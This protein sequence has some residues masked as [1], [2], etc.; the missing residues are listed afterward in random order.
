MEDPESFL[1]DRTSRSLD[2]PQV[3]VSGSHAAGAGSEPPRVSSG[4]PRWGATTKLVIGLTLAAISAF[5]LVRFLNIVGPLLLS[6]I[7]AYLIYPLAEQARI[8]LRIPWRLAVTLLFLVL[9]ILLIGSIAVGG[10]A[11]IEQLQKL[12][13][14]LQNAVKGLPEF[15]TELTSRP[16]QVGPFT[17]NTEVLDADAVA[18]Q[19][20]GVVQPV[21]AQAGSSIVSFASG[22]AS[23][24]GWM[25]FILLI[26]YFILSE[27]G[28]FPNR[29]FKITIPGHDEDIRRLGMAL[30]RIW[31]AFLRGQL[32]I[33]LITILIYSVVLGSYRVNFF[34]GLALLAGLARFIPYVGPF[35]AWTTYGLVAFFQGHTVFG[36][37]PQAYVL[38]VVGTAYVM[39]LF[40]DN[41]VMPRL[42]SNALRIHPAAVMISALV[43]LN[44]LGVVGMVLAAPVLAT[45][46][47][48]LD[49]IFAK[50]FDQ[51]PWS[52]MHTIPV[53]EPPPPLFP[54]L[55]QRFSHLVRRR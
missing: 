45:V 36:L 49:Y 28:G 51:D 29:L 9:V 4:S 31:E 32:T 47:L 30:N 14:F 44:L 24:I 35:A 41:Y 11:V 18:Q 46:K 38:L 15:V 5:L 37:S 10:L 34:F 26:A 40:L 12:I 33:V 52:N 19:L 50:L 43:A 22:T 23:V 8:S 3:P 25:F 55:R 54:A 16:L 1:D 7:L 48:F 27:S 39:D 21:L 53:P 20:L 42:M 2:D 13:L 17:I 6:F